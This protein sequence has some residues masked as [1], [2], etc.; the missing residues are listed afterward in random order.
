MEFSQFTA[1]TDIVMEITVLLTSNNWVPDSMSA[2]EPILDLLG[3][4][5]T[6]LQDF[7]LH[8]HYMD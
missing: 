8:D 1:S 7:C 3:V 4:K 6:V 2:L 5:G